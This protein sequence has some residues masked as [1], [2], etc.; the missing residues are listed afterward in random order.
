MTAT[1]LA[2]AM[3][4]CHFSDEESPLSFFF[5]VVLQPAA[6]LGRAPLRVHRSISEPFGLLPGGLSA[7][8]RGCL[9]VLP[10]VRSNAS[11]F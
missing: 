7:I 10:M 4:S 9:S 2:G 1:V 11:H 6:F 8:S 5:I 3:T